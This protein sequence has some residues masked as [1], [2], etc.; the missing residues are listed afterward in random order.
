MFKPD[1]VKIDKNGC[2]SARDM[3]K[4]AVYFNRIA[5]SVGDR[6]LM[7]NSREQI[8][9]WYKHRNTQDRVMVAMNRQPRRS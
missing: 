6:E 1:H 3:I 7:A 9:R 4:L 2:I 8:M 5:R